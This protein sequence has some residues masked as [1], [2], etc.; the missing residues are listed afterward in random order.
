MLTFILS[1]FLTEC[2]HAASQPLNQE[3]IIEYLEEVTI[4]LVISSNNEVLADV[5]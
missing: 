1:C 5:D 4:M 2:S 3:L